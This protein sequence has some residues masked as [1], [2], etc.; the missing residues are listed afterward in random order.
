LD[1]IRSIRAI[2]LTIP[3]DSS[4]WTCLF[5]A[6]Q[7]LHTLIEVQSASGLRGVGSIYT[8]GEL[9]E[10]SL[11]LLKPFLIGASA[12]DPAA[13]AEKLHQHTFWQGRGGA[14]THTISGV[15]I[16]LWDL[17]GQITRQP[18]S[19][20]LGG[21]QRSSIK[22]YASLLWDEIHVVRDRL[23]AGLSR[24]FKAFKLGWGP[25]GRKDHRT[26][27]A[28]VAAARETVGPDI[29][30]MVDAGAS[31]GFWP[32]G[33]KW[34][35]HTAE[36]LSRYDVT[37][38]EEPLRPDDL[39]CYARLTE[40]APLPISGGEVLTRRQ[41]FIEWIDRR[42]VDIIQPDVTKCGGI[43]EQHFIGRYADAHGI[44]LISHGWNTALGLA[45]DL[46]LASAAPRARFVE[47][48]TPS[49]YIDE[50]FVAS[51]K[52]DS[53]GCLAIPDGP[54]LGFE[55]NPDGIA[56]LSSTREISTAF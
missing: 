15:D 11:R 25:F 42:T 29:E 34:A 45:A 2:P 24:G 32:H 46:Q 41:A 50:L 39:E 47:Y 3:S 43:S 38:F 51:P 1:T 28:L 56:K 40:N 53:A 31:E 48:M 26:D 21:R 55:W 36:M 54:G 23:N 18:I 17:F 30:L 10:A 13:V 44:M 12:C 52:L 27:E 19:R 33:Y 35:L 22:A 14:V 5:G 20:L 7:N 37:W 6:D 16:A 9:V 8:S 4:D 49:P